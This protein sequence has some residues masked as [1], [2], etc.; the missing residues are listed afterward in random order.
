MVSNKMK[1]SILS[2]VH[3]VAGQRGIVYE[4]F[5]NRLCG[6]RSRY[7]IDVLVV[8]SEGS[9]SRKATEARGF[10]YMEYANHPVSDKWAAG[11]NEMRKDDPDYVMT[12]DSDD[13]LSDALFDIYWRLMQEGEHDSIGVNDSYFLSLNKPPTDDYRCGYWRG[14]P[15][16]KMLGCSRV[17]SKKILHAANWNL[18]VRGRNFLLNAG[19]EQILRRLPISIRKKNINVK[20]EGVLHI[21]IKSEGNITSFNKL[22]KRMVPV[23]VFMLL[24]R[25]LPESECALIL[26]HYG[27]GQ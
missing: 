6:L 5:L 2:T 10:R 19:T 18:W 23:D 17:H 12:L 27:R 20:E 24:K 8:G 26:Q 4:F 11:L 21:D 22:K 9:I 14:Y 1:V 3:N 7:D 16:G 13:L 15:N 25:H